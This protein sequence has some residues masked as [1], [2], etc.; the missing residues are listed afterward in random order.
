[1]S[2]KEGRNGGLHDLAA[3]ILP[4][5]TTQDTRNY[6]R[7]RNRNHYRGR[8]PMGLYD[9]HL[10]RPKL[11]KC[12]RIPSCAL[13][14]GEQRHRAVVRIRG[15][16]KGLREAVGDLR[17]IRV[18]RREGETPTR[19]HEALTP[20]SESW[21]RSPGMRWTGDAGCQTETFG[22][23]RWAAERRQPLW[24]PRTSK[25]LAKRGS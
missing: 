9:L 12:R 6:R 11:C 15:V 4:V 3:L 14:I 24:M 17:P 13:K 10:V 2:G 22:S 19:R 21:I 18:V 23:R 25:L 8:A 16:L 5:A 7:G 20:A 1:M